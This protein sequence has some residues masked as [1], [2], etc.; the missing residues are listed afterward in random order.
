MSLMLKERNG[1]EVVP[2]PKS[3]EGQNSFYRELGASPQRSRIRGTCLVHH[4]WQ[5]LSSSPGLEV[6]L[7]K[8][9]MLRTYTIWPSG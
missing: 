1:R 3:A 8:G 7:I 6:N 9:K 4:Q 5:H 2:K